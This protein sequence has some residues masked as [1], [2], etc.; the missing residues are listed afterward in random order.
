[1]T[2]ILLSLTLAAFALVV[3][4]DNLVDYGS[5]FAFVRHVL[6]MDTT[7]P[8]NALSGRALTQPWM[9]HAGYVAIIVGEA[10]TGLLL[11]LGSIVLWRAR[12]Q[13]ASAF[14]AAKRWVIAGCGL[15]FVLWFLGFMVV[16][17]EWFAMW[18]SKVWNGQEAAFRF[19]MAIVG[20][21]VFVNQ[22]DGEVEGHR[23]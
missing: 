9:W 13:S 3:A 2:K 23:R 1:M 18:Q 4:Y 16:G 15:G 19:Y 22:A 5:N 21:L 10:A 20:V 6:S 8:G 11:L 7:F 12:R 14:Q 17:G